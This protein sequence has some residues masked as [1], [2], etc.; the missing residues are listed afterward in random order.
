M[1]PAVAIDV[2]PN[3]A[4]ED[5]NLTEALS[6]GGGKV[7]VRILAD[8][9]LPIRGG[10]E[11]VEGRAPAA[12]LPLLLALPPIAFAGLLM[13]RRRAD[14]FA[15]DVGLRRRRGALRT[16]LGAIGKR[17][18]LESRD[19]SSVLRRY[20][21]DRVGAEGQALTPRECAERLSALGAS[22]GLV[23]DVRDAARALRSRRLR[24]RRQR[25]RCRRP[26]C[27]P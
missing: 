12:M 13:A 1:A 3:G 22:E 10:A 14:R 21:G 5:L 17:G 11:L 9:L 6:A 27:A 25:G 7:A 26:S 8:D 18:E 16:A 20:I 19:A 15:S 23:G 2:A 24:R 4:A